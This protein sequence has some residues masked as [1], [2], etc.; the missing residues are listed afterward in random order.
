MTNPSATTLWFTWRGNEFFKQFKFWCI[1]LLR[2]RV[3]VKNFPRKYTTRKSKSLAFQ[4]VYIFDFC[5]NG[6][7][8]GFINSEYHLTCVIDM[9]F[10]SF[11]SFTFHTLYIDR[12]LKCQSVISIHFVG[13]DEG[14]RH[15]SLQFSFVIL[16]GKLG[17]AGGMVHRLYAK[18]IFTR[19]LSYSIFQLISP[20]F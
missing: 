5:F 12:A 2:N 17:Y 16:T 6:V 14:G 10:W 13:A 19:L 8:C 15:F 9:K 3:S 4:R 1:Q 18:C 11:L 20:L 7:M